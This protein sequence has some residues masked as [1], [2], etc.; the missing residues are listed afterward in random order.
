MLTLTYFT[1]IVKILRGPPP[2]FL[3]RDSI[4]LK[5]CQ[6]AIQSSL[7]KNLEKFLD[8][9]SRVCNLRTKNTDYAILKDLPI[10][11]TC[12][13]TTFDLKF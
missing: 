2:H 5:L 10:Q 4:L 1:F 12:T 8:P 13:F 3:P 7:I 11:F 9:L 6:F